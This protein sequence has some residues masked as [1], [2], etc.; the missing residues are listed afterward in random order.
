MA[1]GKRWPRA[2]EAPQRRQG[3]P[4]PR[5]TRVPAE[6]SR[7]VAVVARRDLADG[8]ERAKMRI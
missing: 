6:H 1:E 7:L 2:P 3:N 4:R 8:Y 5:N